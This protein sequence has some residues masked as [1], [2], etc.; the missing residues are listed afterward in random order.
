MDASPPSH[1][2]Q[3]LLCLL[4]LI[5]CLS[6]M[7]T[8]ASGRGRVLLGSIEGF[9]VKWEQW[10]KYSGTRKQGALAGGAHLEVRG[11]FIQ[12]R[13]STH[14]QSPERTQHVFIGVQFLWGIP[15]RNRQLHSQTPP[16]GTSPTLTWGKPTQ[17]SQ[18]YTVAR[19]Y[20]APLW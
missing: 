16:N 12:T 9:V 6:R 1:P 17:V 11:P 20:I 10:L 8:K 7:N 13:Q 4:H 14:R 3:I 5:S 19:L 15:T 18:S 2:Y